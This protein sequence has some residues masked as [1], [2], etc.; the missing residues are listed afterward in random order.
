MGELSWSVGHRIL[1]GDWEK[2]NWA[3]GVRQGLGE[4]G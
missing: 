1:K 3:V 4:L 2:G